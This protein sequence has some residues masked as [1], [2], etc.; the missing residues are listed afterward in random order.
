MRSEKEG[1]LIVIRRRA[2][3]R[4]VGRNCVRLAIEVVVVG[5]MLQGLLALRSLFSIHDADDRLYTLQK[6]SET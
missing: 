6:Q 5:L 1:P 4:I 2:T 3:K